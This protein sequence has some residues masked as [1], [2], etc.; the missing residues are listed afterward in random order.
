MMKKQQRWVGK[1]LKKKKNVTTVMKLWRAKRILYMKERKAQNSRVLELMNFSKAFL[2]VAWLWNTILCKKFFKV[3]GKMVV[4]F[5]D[6]FFFFFVYFS[7]EEFVM[8]DSTC[9]PQS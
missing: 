7:C 5:V 3:H 8:E 6:I 9:Q 4:Y 2:A 1:K